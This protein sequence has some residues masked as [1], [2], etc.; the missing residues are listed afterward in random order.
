M[1]AFQ[2]TE[3]KSG[4]FRFLKGNLDQRTKETNKAINI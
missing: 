1:D 3:H 2:T 4:S